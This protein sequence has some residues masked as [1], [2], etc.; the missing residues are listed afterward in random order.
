MLRA[1]EGQLF[2][3]P[4]D[5]PILGVEEDRKHCIR[6]RSIISIASFHRVAQHFMHL[7]FIYSQVESN[8]IQ[9]RAIEI[10]PATSHAD[11]QTNK[12]N[13]DAPMHPNT[14]QSTVVRRSP[15]ERADSVWHLST[16]NRATLSYSTE[17]TVMQ[18]HRALVTRRVHLP[19][20]QAQHTLR[21]RNF[22]TLRCTTA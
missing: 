1:S 6:L 19:T 16:T 18:Q 17:A 5:P 13:N 14:A 7:W 21:L 2:F 15:F 9:T 22:R 3:R 10:I 20:P 12:I 4:P 11:H 8:A